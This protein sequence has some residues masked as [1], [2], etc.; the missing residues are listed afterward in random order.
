LPR[1]AAL[2]NRA[3]FSGDTD[4][5]ISGGI[6]SPI[7]ALLYAIWRLLLFCLAAVKKPSGKNKQN[8]QTRMERF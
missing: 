8:G 5:A 1:R 4:A 6:A 7:R 3:L 2:H